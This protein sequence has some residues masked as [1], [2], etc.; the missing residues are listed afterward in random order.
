MPDIVRLFL[1]SALAFAFAY[2][3][4]RHPEVYGR[5]L[6]FPPR[7]VRALMLFLMATLLFLFLVT[8][9]NFARTR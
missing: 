3:A 9:V 5:P 1:G 4:Y 2:Y 6:R 7:F 8:V